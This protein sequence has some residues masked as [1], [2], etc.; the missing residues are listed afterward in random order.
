[1]Y[2]EQVNGEQKERLV[3]PLG[4]VAKGS[5]WYL[6]ASRKGELRN[7]RV[8]RIHHAKVEEKVFN[9]RHDFNLAAY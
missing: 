2:Y 5:N 4:L 3:E 1:M 9:R 6:V 8:S 7:Y